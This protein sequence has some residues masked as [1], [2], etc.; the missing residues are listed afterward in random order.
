MAEKSKKI[1]FAVLGSGG[2]MGGEVLNLL[3]SE[4]SSQI[5]IVAT[6][7]R[8]DSFLELLKADVVI[9]FSL[10][11][12]FMLFLA[13]LK[14]TKTKGL[15]LFVIGSTGWSASQ[16]KEL[17]QLSKKTK[18]LKASNFSLGIQVLR[19]VLK[20]NAMLLEELRFE[21]SILE[22]HHVHKKDSPS[23]T[24]LTLK[25]DLESVLREKKRLA[26]IEAL[27]EGEEVG[28][29]EVK[30]SGKNEVLKF[31][32]QALSR[33]IF[34]RGAITVALWLKRSKSL[35]SKSKKLFSVEDYLAAITK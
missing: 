16:E 6:P 26:A 15:P 25:G 3:R 28:F 23:G 20:E 30:F 22:V 35:K 4:F 7:K 13:E 9:D 14:K 29:H 11:E 1:K 27:R 5:E 34:A 32:H 17:I 10:P 18:I 21:P 31:S 19:K 8:G 12:A 24:A 2:R 33:E